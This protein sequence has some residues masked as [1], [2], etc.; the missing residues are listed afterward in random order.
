MIMVRVL[1]VQ[2]VGSGV[3]GEVP[4]VLGVLVMMVILLVM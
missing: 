4:C 3:Q 2:I 1:V